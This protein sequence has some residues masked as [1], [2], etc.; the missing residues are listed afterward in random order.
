[1]Q[2]NDAIFKGFPVH[3][4]ALPESCKQY[5]QVQHSLTIDEDLIVYVCHLLIPYKLRREVLNQLH[6][7]HQGTLHT[8]QRAH[9]TVYWPGI[10]NDVD[11]LIS[12]CQQYQ[13][14]A[15]SIPKNQC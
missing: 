15:P 14:Y 13:S 10:D 8:K 7:S 4:G 1:M 12:Q 6:E 3:K 11:N 2:L 9:L 5:W